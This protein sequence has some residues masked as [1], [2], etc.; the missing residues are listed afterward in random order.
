LHSP[1]TFPPEISTLEQLDNLNFTQR[2]EIHLP[3]RWNWLDLWPIFSQVM[4]GHTSL[5]LVLSS[6]DFKTVILGYIGE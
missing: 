6:R 1:L 3:N 2:L 5:S 4:D